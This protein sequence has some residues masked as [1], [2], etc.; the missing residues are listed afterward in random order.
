MSNAVNDLFNHPAVRKGLFKGR[1]VLSAAL[2][3][4]V[5][6]YMQ[7][8]WLVPGLA[9][10]MFGQLIQTWCFASLVKNRELTA[11]GPYLMCRNPMYVGRY[12]LI[13][14]FVMLLANP[15]LIGAYTLVY[16]LY[17]THRVSR[18]EQRLRGWL[19]EPYIEYCKKVNRYFP[20]LR[21]LADRGLYFFD[22]KM[23]LE[24]NAHWN[25]LGTLIAYGLIYALRLTFKL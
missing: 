12:F 13:L 18:E 10:S 15:W 24:N 16:W 9:V 1:F 11:R 3:V 23:F 21:P 25:I 14:G 7:P 22:G 5:A 6:Y 17:M 4:P 19:G 8:W 2:L 20:S